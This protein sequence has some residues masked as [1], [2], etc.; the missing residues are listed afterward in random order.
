MGEKSVMKKIYCISAIGSL[1]IPLIV[2]IYIFPTKLIKL[3]GNDYTRNDNLVYGITSISL[4]NNHLE[5]KAWILMPN[6][7]QGYAVLDN[8]SI[9]LFDNAEKQFYKCKES[10][11]V[12]RDPSI[13]QFINDGRDYQSSIFHSLI[14]LE[15]INLDNRN[16]DIYVCYQYHEVNY[17]K[18]TNYSIIDG[19]VEME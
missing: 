13:N 1:L 16:I 10:V 7:E 14:D 2:L 18:K 8:K 4:V 11:S 9:W 15:S 6:I 5:V 17:I 12:G 19:V 3:V